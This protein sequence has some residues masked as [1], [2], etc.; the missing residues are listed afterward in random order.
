MGITHKGVTHLPALG[1]RLTKLQEE[2]LVKCV[3]YFESFKIDQNVFLEESKSL[4]RTSHSIAFTMNMFTKKISGIPEWGIPY[5]DQLKSDTIQVFA[6]V[7][8]S[9]KR[10]IHLYERACIEDFLRYVYFFDHKIE[11]I[12]L[13]TY[14]KKF[15]SIDSMIDWLERY[16]TL[17]P[18][19]KPVSENC[20]ELASRYAELSRTVHGTTMAD[21]QIVESLQDTGRQK[22][23]PQKEEKI[24]K[25]L[26]GAIFFLLS[27]FHIKNYRQLQL[28]EKTLVCQHLSE[29]Q[30]KI[31]SGL[32]R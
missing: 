14:P 7:I 29:K 10:T 8:M 13:Q 32:S 22:I 9:A 21:Q 23:E 17:T 28:D 27:A 2:D 18:F 25:G 11:H 5:L 6:S 16:P 1:A 12:L 20:M 3:D 19:E 4:V 26:F 15:Q 24:M 30:I 31:L